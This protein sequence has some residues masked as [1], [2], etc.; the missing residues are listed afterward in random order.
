MT[1]LFINFNTFNSKL[2]IYELAIGRLL[3]NKY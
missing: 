2:D 3:A 1:S